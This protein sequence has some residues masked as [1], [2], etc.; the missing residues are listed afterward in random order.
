MKQICMSLV[1]CIACVSAIQAAETP[2]AKLHTVKLISKEVIISSPRAADQFVLGDKLVVKNAAGR[3][4]V[5]TV[6]FPMMS[7][8]K[9]KPEKADIPYLETLKQGLPVFRYGPLQQEV[10]KYHETWDSDY[11][12]KFRKIRFIKEL[13]SD[14][15]A[16]TKRYFIVVYD[17]AGTILR[18]T[19][20][21]DQKKGVT[22]FYRNDRIIK[23]QY[24]RDN[25]TVSRTLV[26]EYYDSGKLKQAGDVDVDK[27]TSKVTRY[28]ESGKLIP[29][30]ETEK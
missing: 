4:F 7:V 11:L 28:D 22:D 30:G 27:N 24:H 6:A 23:K 20:V 13:Q 1:M 19:E 25:G 26:Y 14:Q 12:T 2:V 5:L 18:T 8:A 10:T 17:G 3:E 16:S 21:S 29:D 15:L 9:C